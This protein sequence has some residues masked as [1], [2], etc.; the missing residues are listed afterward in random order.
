[1]DAQ[2]VRIDTKGQASFY[3][4]QQAIPP[5]NLPACLE[6]ASSLVMYRGFHSQAPDN[7]I[8]RRTLRAPGG[9]FAMYK[10]GPMSGPWNAAEHIPVMRGQPVATIFH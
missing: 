10:P 1:M 6:Q 7:F 4:H 3:R 8:G 2:F 5:R 9:D